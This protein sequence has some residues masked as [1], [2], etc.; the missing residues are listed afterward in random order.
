M[1]FFSGFSFPESLRKKF[2]GNS[3]PL[4][5]FTTLTFTLYPVSL[6]VTGSHERM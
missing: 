5:I 1:G 6:P 4:Q 3:R 2:P